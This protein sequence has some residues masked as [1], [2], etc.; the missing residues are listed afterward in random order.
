M[1]MCT[2]VRYR[3]YTHTAGGL[4]SLRGHAAVSYK[5]RS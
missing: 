1:C 3:V 4:M 2:W 5:K